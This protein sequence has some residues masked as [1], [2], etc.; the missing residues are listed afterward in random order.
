MSNK[1]QADQ[2]AE[3]FDD[4]LI[5]QRSVGGRQFDYVAVAE[6]VARLNKVLGPENWNYEV[7]KCHVQP[8]YKEHVIAHVR[9]TANIDGST[10]YK[11]QYGGA[12]IKI[13][14]SGGVMDLG[15]DFKTAASDAFKKA[16]QGLGIALHLARSEEALTLD[17]EESYPVPQEQWEVFVGNFRALDDEKKDLFRKWFVS[18]EL[19]G[20]KPQRGMDAE[21]FQKAQVEV[22]RLSFGAEEVPPEE[23]P[24]ETY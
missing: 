16:C 3:P 4:M 11:E 22:I 17:A 6:Y 24:E 15:N 18:Q 2:L 7:L 9:V 20:E 23:I 21:G 12:K 10:C 5:Y 13:M 1:S 8:E 19:G 14:K